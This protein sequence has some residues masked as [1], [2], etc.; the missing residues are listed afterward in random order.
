M[1]ELIGKS[2]ADCSTEDFELFKALVVEGGQVSAGKLNDRIRA[3]ETLV[4]ARVDDEIAGVTGLKNSSNS[5][6]NRIS[7]KSDVDLSP[8]LFPYEL[9]WVYV[10]PKFQRCGISLQMSNKA[11][12]YANGNGVFATSR[13]EN[14]FMHRTLEKV[15][16]KPA[17][18]PYSS[19]NG[20]ESVQLF[21]RSSN[22]TVPSIDSSLKLEMKN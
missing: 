9:G 5:Y 17:G 7:K 19:R 4:F 1:L 21:I 10:L 12:T 3:S 16:F 18:K 20:L 2:P 14:H 6:R 13:T 11:L 15:G 22:C 8:K